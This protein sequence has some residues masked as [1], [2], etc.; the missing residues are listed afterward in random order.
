MQRGT[1]LLLLAFNQAN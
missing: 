1:H